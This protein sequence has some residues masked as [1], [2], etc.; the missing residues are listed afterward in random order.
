[1]CPYNYKM[2]NFISC[3]LLLHNINDKS[4]NVCKQKVQFIYRLNF[5]VVNPVTNN[6]NDFQ[7]SLFFFILIGEH[8]FHVLIR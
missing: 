4:E 3:Q 8:A 5:N 6:L 2:F 7:I 1:M